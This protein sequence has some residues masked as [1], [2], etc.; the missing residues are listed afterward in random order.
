MPGR[1]GD[2]L[3]G[4]PGEGVL[5]PH[6]LPLQ[7][8]S[9]DVRAAPDLSFGVESDSVAAGDVWGLHCAVRR[10]RGLVGCA[11]DMAVTGPR[12]PPVFLGSLHGSGVRIVPSSLQR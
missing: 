11:G 4:A 7:C 12:Q 1:G 5:Q 8:I 9:R 3:P 10:A 6:V 2:P